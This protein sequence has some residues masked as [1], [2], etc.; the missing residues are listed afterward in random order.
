MI[1]GQAAF[2]A[3]QVIGGVALI[4]YAF[5]PPHILSKLGRKSRHRVERILIVIGGL[6]LLVIGIWGELPRLID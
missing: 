5:C 1:T 2:R 6:M 3:I 4:A